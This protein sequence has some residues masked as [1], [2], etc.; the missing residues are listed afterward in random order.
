MG[1][2]M[3]VCATV[4]ERIITMHG[5]LSPELKSLE[6]IRKLKRPAEIP[7]FGLFCDLL[8]SDPAAEAKTWGENDRGISFTFG[9]KVVSKFLAD[10]NLDLIARAHQVVEDGYEFFAKRQLVTI[11]SAPAYCREFDNCGALMN[12]DTDLKCS[13]VVLKPKVKAFS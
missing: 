8:W 5:G 9:E 10:F 11:F 4:A 3:P 6:H 2:V 7:E 12:V 13:F 1:N